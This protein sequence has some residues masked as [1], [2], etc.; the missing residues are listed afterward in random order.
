[1]ASDSENGKWHQQKSR[2][3]TLL[4]IK[5]LASHLINSPLYSIWD[6]QYNL[7]V[8]EIE[9]QILQNQNQTFGFIHCSYFFDVLRVGGQGIIPTQVLI[10]YKQKSQVCLQVHE[11]DLFSGRTRMMTLMNKYNAINLMWVLDMMDNCSTTIAIAKIKIHLNN[12]K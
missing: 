1:M 2:P 9:W 8:W 12:V 11:N 4:Q 3:H 10:K 5:T 7:L 6:H